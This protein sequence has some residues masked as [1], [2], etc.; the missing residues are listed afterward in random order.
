MYFFL[1]SSGLFISPRQTP[2]RVGRFFIVELEIRLLL[3]VW[4]L[5]TNYERTFIPF[6]HLWKSE[7]E[8][9]WI[10]PY[11]RVQLKVAI[12][13]HSRLGFVWIRLPL[14]WKKASNCES[15]KRKKFVY[16][17]V[18]S[19]RSQQ[20]GVHVYNIQWGSCDLVICGKGTS[21]SIKK[22]PEAELTAFHHPQKRG[23][24]T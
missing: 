7:T 10:I 1:N 21:K 11:E 19:L 8:H 2:G 5:G 9:Y 18:W 14:L 20:A 13:A 22:S 12:S 15:S 17:R 3:Q 4:A 16:L 24:L 23:L 6:L